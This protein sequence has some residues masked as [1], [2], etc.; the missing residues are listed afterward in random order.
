M[1]LDL[2]TAFVKKVGMIPTEETSAISLAKNVQG[3][4]YL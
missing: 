3:M 1:L 2:P 4:P